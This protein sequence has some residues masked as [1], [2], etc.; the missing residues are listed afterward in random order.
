MS[1]FSGQIRLWHSYAKV[2]PKI[3]TTL[4]VEC[5]KTQLGLCIYNVQHFFRMRRPFVQRRIFSDVHGAS[6]LSHPGS[7][8]LSRL[9]FRAFGVS[10]FWG[11]KK[12]GSAVHTSEICGRAEQALGFWR[13]SANFM[14]ALLTRMRACKLGLSLQCNGV[15]PAFVWGRGIKYKLLK[16][17]YRAR[18]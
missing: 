15:Y 1:L 5:T 13:P 17:A 11:V 4:T 7:H 10:T 9:D 6:P 14:A 2:T 3:H 18:I 12:R 8:L 16:Y